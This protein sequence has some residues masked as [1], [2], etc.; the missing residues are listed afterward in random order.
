VSKITRNIE[1]FTGSIPETYVSA[2]WWVGACCVLGL[3]AFAGW[4]CLFYT[5]HDLSDLGKQALA[6]LCIAISV[7]PVLLIKPSEEAQP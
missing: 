6:F 7:A 1:A 5:P 4:V 2:A 3:G